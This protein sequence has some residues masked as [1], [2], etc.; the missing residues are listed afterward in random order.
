LINVAECS[1]AEENVAIF[2]QV[3]WTS[4]P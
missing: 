2:C 3:G 4:W 1:V